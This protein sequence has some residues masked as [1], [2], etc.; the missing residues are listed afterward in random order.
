[1]NGRGYRQSIQA[2]LTINR[3]SSRE[4]RRAEKRI[5]RKNAKR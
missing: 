2:A 5:A 1:M 4:R 3:L